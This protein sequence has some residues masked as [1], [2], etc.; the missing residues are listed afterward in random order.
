[1]MEM[2]KK[3]NMSSQGKDA[4][5]KTECW[6]SAIWKYFERVVNFIQ[7]IYIYESLPSSLS[8]YGFWL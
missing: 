7:E 8:C 2:D 5:L 3:E 6:N 4:D 1:M